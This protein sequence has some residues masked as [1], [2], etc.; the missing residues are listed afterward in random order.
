[1]NNSTYFTHSLAVKKG[2]IGERIVQQFLE[3]VR[4]RVL[5]SPVGGSFCAERCLVGKFPL[6]RTDPPENRKIAY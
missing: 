3:V 4:H 6:S 1:M 5:N 2:N